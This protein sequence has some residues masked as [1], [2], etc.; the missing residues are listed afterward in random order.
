MLEQLQKLSA[1][2]FV[3]LLLFIFAVVAMVFTLIS[4]GSLSED[5]ISNI[6]YLLFGLAT[7]GA[8]GT[9]FGARMRTGV[10]PKWDGKVERRK[11]RP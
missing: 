7:G 4:E 3:V 2:R 9:A 6:M 10:K 8:G 5:T 1:W 11:K